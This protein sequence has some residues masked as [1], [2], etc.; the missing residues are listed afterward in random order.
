MKKSLSL[1]ILL[2][3]CVTALVFAHHPAEDM[4]DEDL[5]AEID[6][7]LQDTPH[8]TIIDDMTTELTTELTFVTDD[9][10][11][12]DDLLDDGLL[13]D[14]SLLDGDV[15]VTI[16]FPD[17]VEVAGSS[18]L[19]SVEELSGEKNGPSANFDKKWSE[20]GGPVRIQIM[21]IREE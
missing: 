1:T 11:T 10:A 15:T 16:T 17:E 2:L 13:D 9:T 14:V 6:L 20:W 18:V 4:I 19:K 12:A 3:V 7:M 21:V 8:V 5:Y